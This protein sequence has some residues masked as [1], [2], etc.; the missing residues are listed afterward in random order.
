MQCGCDRC[1]RPQQ[2]LRY[3]R[4]AFLIS[5][6]Y[7]VTVH[8]L[9][10][11][12]LAESRNSAFG[13]ETVNRK[14]QATTKSCTGDNPPPS[15]CY[16]SEA[17]SA[18]FTAVLCDPLHVALWL[19]RRLRRAELVRSTAANLQQRHLVFRYCFQQ[20]DR[21]LDNSDDVCRRFRCDAFK[22]PLNLMW[23]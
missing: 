1:L 15:H 5:K 20:L 6:V 16:V 2:S 14:Q 3:C 17:I 7:F 8:V 4:F 9:A 22:Q 18:S 23:A 12:K 10:N 19:R 11:S 13:C 21:I